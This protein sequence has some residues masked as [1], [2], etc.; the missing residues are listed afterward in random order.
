[1]DNNSNWTS[2]YVL[3]ISGSELHDSDLSIDQICIIDS[4]AIGSARSCEF[5]AYEM[6]YNEVE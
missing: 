1:M 3:K 4:D 6:Y 2:R 5:N